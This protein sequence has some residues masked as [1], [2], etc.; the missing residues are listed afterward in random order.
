MRLG[1]D[2][3]LKRKGDVGEETKSQGAFM[4][5]LGIWWGLEVNEKRVR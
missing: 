3:K 5:F 4:G 2:L 1:E